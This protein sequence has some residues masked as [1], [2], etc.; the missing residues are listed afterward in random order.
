MT[1]LGYKEE[2]WRDTESLLIEAQNNA[3]KT[4]Y[5][6]ANIDYSQNSKC[7]RSGDRVNHIISECS[8]LAQKEYESRNDWAGK[9]FNSALCKKLEFDHIDKWYIQKPE[10]L[11]E[12]GIHK[13]LWDFIDE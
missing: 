13:L 2:T 1:G 7:W 12:N 9:V 8:K 11:Q 10:Y 5:I 6:K 4:N 3:L